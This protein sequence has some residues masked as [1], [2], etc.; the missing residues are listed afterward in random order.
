MWPLGFANEHV[1]GNRL[2]HRLE[3]GF[4][5]LGDTR[6]DR[7]SRSTGIYLAVE[8]DRIAEATRTE[9]RQRCSPLISNSS[10]C[11]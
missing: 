4:C 8:T 6:L 11:S 9:M 10:S 7:Y 3:Q 5:N 1:L 2:R